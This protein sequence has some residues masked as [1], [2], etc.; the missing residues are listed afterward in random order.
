MSTRRSERY[1]NQA[2]AAT[3]TIE[4]RDSM[5]GALLGRGV[6]HRTAGESEFVLART[7]ERNRADFERMFR[8][9]AELSA[10]AIVRLRETP[11]P[12]AGAVGED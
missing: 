6:D 12:P 7:S 1:S 3:I 4:A 9:W 5:S 8:S 11:A 10:D 2:G